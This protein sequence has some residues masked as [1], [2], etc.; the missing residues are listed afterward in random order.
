MRKDFLNITAKFS[1][2]LHVEKLV[3]A[4]CKEFLSLASC[5]YKDSPEQYLDSICPEKKNSCLEEHLLASHPE[6]DLQIIMPVYNVSQYIDDCMSSVLAQKTHYSYLLIVVDDGSTDN[7][8]ILLQKYAGY[9]NVKIIRQSNQGPS[10]ARNN[11]LQFIN[12]RYVAFMDADDSFPENAIET[13]I[14]KA[15]QYQIDMLEGSHRFFRG[16]KTLQVREFAD[17]QSSTI[18]FTSFAWGKIYRAHIWQHIGFP[19]GYWFEDMMV[20]LILS[21]MAT[22]QA[23]IREV[24]Y[25]YRDTPTGFTRAYNQDKR[26]VESYW[27]TKQ[28]L[29][30]AKEL[31]IVPTSYYYE[32]FLQCCVM[33]TRR[34]AI[35][36]DRKADYALFEA[37]RELSSKYFKGVHA[38]TPKEKRIESA[39][40]N[41]DFKEYL[42]YCLFLH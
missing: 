26:R 8:P 35:L 42:L 36:G 15:D 25:N 17:T 38:Q 3:Y 41:N 29:A 40:L 22:K 20:V 14:S 39:F 23:T 4:L 12:A 2:K 6:Y 30:D 28:L 5:N 10:A 32:R 27:I 16:E 11:G 18:R 37:Q 33:S 34:V 19:L 7:T 13:M 24:I 9:S 1:K 31:G 21:P